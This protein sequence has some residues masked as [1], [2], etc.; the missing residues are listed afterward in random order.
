[1]PVGPVVRDQETAEFFD[2][3]AAGQFLLRKCDACGAISA[4]QAKQ[5]G[6]CGSTEL[7]W[8]P[9]AGGASVISWSVTHS[10]PGPDGDTRAQVIAIAQLDEGPWWLSQIVDAD[11]AAVAAGTRLRVDFQRAT[12]DSE[13]V[14]VFRL[15]G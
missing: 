2:G 9:A 1:M 8:Q 5:C 10:K 7:G 13:Y 3:T 15:A 4:P 11:P 14:P 12:D 6:N